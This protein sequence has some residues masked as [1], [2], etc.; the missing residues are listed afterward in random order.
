ML[1]C[2]Y[3]GRA[4]EVSGKLRGLVKDEM[5]DKASVASSLAAGNAPDTGPGNRDIPSP[6][7]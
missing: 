4:L 3:R 6:Q 1:F 2:S 7:P 5:K